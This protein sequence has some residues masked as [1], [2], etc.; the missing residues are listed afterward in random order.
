MTC[1]KYARSVVAGLSLAMI[2]G[3]ALAHSNSEGSKM[4]K[5]GGCQ[6]KGSKQSHGQQKRGGGM[7][8]PATV[9]EQLNLT[10]A[11]KVALFNAQTATQAMRDGMRESMRQARE[12]RRAAMSSENFDP[13]AMFQMQDQRMAQRMQARAAIQQQW[14]TF[15]DSLT[16][17][18]KTTVKE[19]M[20]SKGKRGH[21]KGQGHGQGQGSRHGQS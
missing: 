2:S 20:Q 1:R 17:A 4:G 3:A 18:Q 7:Q 15:W 14:L 21:G 9:I 16:D 13:R 10:D 5:G 12:Q 8:L 19:Y 6:D 11:Q